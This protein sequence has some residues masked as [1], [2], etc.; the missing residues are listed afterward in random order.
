MRTSLTFEAKVRLGYALLVL[1]LAAGM[2]YSVHRLSTG[3][4]RQVAWI[5]AEEDERTLVERLRWSSELLVSSGRG[6]L[7]SGVPELLAQVQDARARFEENIRLIRDESLTPTGQGLVEQVQRAGEDFMQVQD[8]LM[9][10]RRQAGD[11]DVLVRRFDTEL[12]PRS[13]TLDRALA[14]LVAYKDASLARSYGDLRRDRGRLELGVYVL[15]GL[16]VLAGIVIAWTFAKLLGSS[17][18]QKDQ[19]L[20]AARNA[21]AIRD[22]VMGVVAHDLRNPLG[23]IIMRASMM[24][25]DATSSTVREH[26]EQI[27]NVAMRM[28]YLIR[29]MLDVASME[30]GRFSLT[31]VACGVDEL[32]RDTRGL[33]DPLA[34]AKRV[35]L[36]VSLKEP[37]LVI[38]ADRE[39]LLQVLSNLLGNALKFTPRGGRVSLTVDREGDEARFAVVDTGPGIARDAVPHVFERFWKQETADA[40]GTGLGLYIAKTII[41]A[42]GGRIW[43]ESEPGHGARFYFTIPLE[44]AADVPAAKAISP[45]QRGGLSSE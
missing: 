4:E 10:A 18:R 45:A 40:K 42:H 29:S 38:A 11:A 17:Y 23:A 43:V 9:T 41:N 30:A 37:G 31:R 14:H 25:E 28:E 44:I 15:L 7:I 12:L 26:A 8:E 36:D 3:S 35:A 27:E 32:L 16:V 39:R 13:R 5:R 6:Y 34:E 21:I 24:G 33:F 19:A 2:A 1:L 20:E 22:E